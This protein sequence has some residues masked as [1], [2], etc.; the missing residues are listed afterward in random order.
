MPSILPGFEYDVFV[1][2]RH[3]DNRSGWVSHFIRSLEQELASTIKEPISIYYDENTYD[4]LLETHQ[5]DKSL[6]SKIKCLVFIP[7]LSQTY[8]DTKSYAWCYEFCAFNASAQKDTLGREVRLGNGNVP[9]RILPV[10]I[11]DLDHDDLAVL[12]AELGST[13]KSVEFIQ[14]GGKYPAACRV[15]EKIMTFRA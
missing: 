7:V 1:S 15:R 4:G 11:H 12:E 2:Y 13:L 14:K 10:K 9:S 6:E 8:C 5:V 3:N